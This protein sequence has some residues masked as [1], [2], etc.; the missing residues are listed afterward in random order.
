MASL[1]TVYR[2][3]SG[4]NLALLILE[5]ALLS[6]L[7]GCSTSRYGRGWGEDATALPGWERMGEAIKSA[8]LDPNTWI[9]TAG[10]AVF[11]LTGLD[12][13]VSDWASEETPLFGSQDNAAN[14]SDNL[15]TASEVCWIS[16][17]LLAPSGE[18]IEEI[19]PAKLKGTAVEVAAVETTKSLTGI[20]KNIARRERPNGMDNAS[21]P[22]G[23]TS[24]SF[25]FSSLA[26]TNLDW[27]DM[28]AGVRKTLQCGLTTVAAGTGWARIEAGVHY[29]SD[30]LFGAALGNF[31][32][33]FF[34]SA[35]LGMEDDCPV[36]VSFAPTSDGAKLCFHILF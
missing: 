7:V 26:R 21:F 14:A 33:V 16:T 6:V 2:K 5:L 23:H 28:N 15:R 31:L 29:P 18:E 32:S 35:F 19:L 4:S 24:S 11:G 1:G 8:A 10:A 9:P 34:T 36:S 22:S 3:P 17:I 30:V 13:S 25:V 27:F 12:E 20:L